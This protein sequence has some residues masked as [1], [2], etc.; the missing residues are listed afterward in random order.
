MDILMLEEYFAL[1]FPRTRATLYAKQDA[2][3]ENLEL[4]HLIIR[5]NLDHYP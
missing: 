3:I 5:L 2:I 1:Y 4:F